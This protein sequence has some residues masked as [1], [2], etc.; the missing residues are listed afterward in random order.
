MAAKKLNSRDHE[1][2]PGNCESLDPS[3][4]C[5]CRA[6]ITRAYREMI[7]RGASH[8]TAVE[9]GMRIYSYHHPGY[10]PGWVNQLVERLVDPTA[11]H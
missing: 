2:A 5:E 1:W 6:A 11:L 7:M 4:S 3:V 8:I 9:V 10:P